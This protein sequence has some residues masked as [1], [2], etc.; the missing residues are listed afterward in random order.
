MNGKLH[1]ID[2]VLGKSKSEEGAESLRHRTQELLDRT[3][4]GQTARVARIVNMH[5]VHKGYRVNVTTEV[6][7]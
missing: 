1:K 4:L 7:S 5:G 3:G 2:Y 6:T